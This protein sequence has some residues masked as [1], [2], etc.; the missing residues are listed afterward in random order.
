MVNTL[1]AG[2][3]Q[4]RSRVMGPVR[5]GTSRGMTSD[6]SYK[7]YLHMRK[8]TSPHQISATNMSGFVSEKPEWKI[9]EAH[10]EAMKS[11]HLRDLMQDAD[12]CSSLMAEFDGITMDFSRQNATADTIVSSFK[13][14]SSKPF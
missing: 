4:N 10:A 9:L 14:H 8:N 7:N 5:A 11:L 12:R 1:L 6:S 13:P 2:K 3:T